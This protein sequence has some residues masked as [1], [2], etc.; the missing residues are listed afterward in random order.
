MVESFKTNTQSD[1]KPFG[2]WNLEVG[3]HER[4]KKARNP[5]QTRDVYV[6]PVETM[7]QAQEHEEERKGK[8]ILG[9]LALVVVVK[10]LLVF[11]DDP[12]PF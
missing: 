4:E 9:W 8:G 10:P 2:Q 11:H 6:G 7:E 5:R 3:T 1:V 12:K